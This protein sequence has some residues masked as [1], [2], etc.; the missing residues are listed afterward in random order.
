MKRGLIFVV[1][2]LVLLLAGSFFIVPTGYVALYRGISDSSIVLKPGLHFRLPFQNV[3]MHAV[4]TQQLLAD[5]TTEHPYL[6]LTTFDKHNLHLGYTLLWKVT[7]PV[8]FFQAQKTQDI[9]SVLRDKLNTTLLEKL[10]PYTLEQVLQVNAQNTPLQLTIDKL[11][12]QFHAQGVTIQGL[13]VTNVTVA[14]AEQPIWLARMNQDEHD[15]LAALQTQTE[16]LAQTLRAETAAKVSKVREDGQAQA[17]K[18]YADAEAEATTIYAQAYDKNPAFYEFYHHLQL[19]KKLLA[20]KQDVLVLSTKTEF[21]KDLSP[22][23]AASQER[24][25][26]S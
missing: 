24:Q 14:D 22:A 1:L 20:S 8:I 5:G 2:L 26:D 9:A 19:Y 25:K 23:R 3:L 11:N 16:N 7:D 10:Q 18:I 13:W 15:K 4:S 12:T 17:S 21:F 6:T